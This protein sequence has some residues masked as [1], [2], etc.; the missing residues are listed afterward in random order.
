MSRGTVG[1][2]RSARTRSLLRLKHYPSLLFSAMSASRC[3]NQALA[4]I[5]AA[6]DLDGLIQAQVGQQ[7]IG[8]IGF[9]YPIDPQSREFGII[10]HQWTRAI[11]VELTDHL[12]Q[13]LIPEYEPSLCPGGNR[14][15][16]WALIGFDSTVGHRRALTCRKAHALDSG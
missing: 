2:Y 11:A 13:G 14:L 6:I 4:A 12:S 10:E 16:G 1:D 3:P 7:R 8:V 15:N 5:A 9:E